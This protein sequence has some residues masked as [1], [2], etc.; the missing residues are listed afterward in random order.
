MQFY[1]LCCICNQNR[2][3][4]SWLLYTPV[5]FYSACLYIW[6]LRQLSTAPKQD[7]SNSQ[8]TFLPTKSNKEKLCLY[9]IQWNVLASQSSYLIYLLSV[10]TSST[11]S[12]AWWLTGSV[13][14][15][16]AVVPRQGLWHHH[17]TGCCSSEQS[18]EPSTVD[19]PFVVFEGLFGCIFVWAEHNR[20]TQDTVIVSVLTH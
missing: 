12:W 10:Y 16:S 11:S 5:V 18:N 2:C 7:G 19:F 14:I 1:R 6:P 8:Y 9:G 20:M 3:H 13:S 15:F 17:V 4:W